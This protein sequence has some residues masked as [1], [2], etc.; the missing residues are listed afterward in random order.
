MTPTPEEP[1]PLE[2]FTADATKRA[3][4][5]ALLRDPVMEEAMTLAED[6]M[7]PRTGTAAD[8][9]QPLSIAKFHQSAGASDFVQRLRGL[10]KE[11]R[12]ATKLT[13]RRLAK[14]EADLP[15]TEET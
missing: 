10:V 2:R 7:R 11:P 3:R 14:S 15:P 9:N 4:L 1:T 13:P 8:A 6:A 12:V 5:Y